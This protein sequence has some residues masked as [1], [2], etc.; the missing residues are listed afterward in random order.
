MWHKAHRLALDIHSAMESAP[1][2][3]YTGLRSQ[4][5]RSAAS[6]PANIAEGCGKSTHA[7]LARFAEI[8][9]GSATEL[10]NHLLFARDAGVID[11]DRYMQLEPVVAEMRRMLFAFVR[12]VRSRTTPH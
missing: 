1:E 2:R 5:L 11:P 7:E 8:A 6:I 9:L 12:A 3:R 4:I 10:D